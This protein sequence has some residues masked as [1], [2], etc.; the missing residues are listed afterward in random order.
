MTSEEYRARGFNVSRNIAQTA[1][2]AAEDY[3]RRAYLAPIIGDKQVADY[4]EEEKRTLSALVFLQMLQAN[5]VF[6]TRAGAKTTAIESSAEAS[7][8]TIMHAA[9]ARARFELD[10]LAQ[11]HSVKP[12]R[13]VSDVCRLYFS[14]NYR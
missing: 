5:G 2:D 12:W 10:A 11:F 6:A 9:F 4:G 7:S 14:T 13:V 1:I 3:I 8:E